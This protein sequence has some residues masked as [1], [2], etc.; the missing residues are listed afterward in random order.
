MLCLL[1]HSPEVAQADH[2]FVLA[3][4]PVHLSVFLVMLIY[5]SIVKRLSNAH[6][7]NQSSACHFNPDDTYNCVQIMA[8]I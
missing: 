2:T 3:F 8:F 6:H 7:D 1:F 5:T 4:L